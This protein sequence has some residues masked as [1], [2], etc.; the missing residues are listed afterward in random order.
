[1]FL[2]FDKSENKACSVDETM[3]FLHARYGREGL[4]LKLKEFFGKDMVENGPEVRPLGHSA[5]LA[6]HLRL[7]FRTYTHLLV[8]ARVLLAFAA[9]LCMLSRAC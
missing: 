2:S 3:A 6:S 9:Y 7:I 4:E 1:M 8:G 5:S